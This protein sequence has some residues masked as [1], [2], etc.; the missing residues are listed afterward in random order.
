EI[1]PDFSASSH[2]SSSP[3]TSDSQLNTQLSLVSSD[4][5]RS[6]HACARRKS[7]NDAQ[8][9]ACEASQLACVLTSAPGSS[10][11]TSQL[12]RSSNNFH[13]RRRSPHVKYRTRAFD[14]SRANARSEE[15]TSE[16]QS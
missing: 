14:G 2:R 1:S 15:H 4:L 10:G 3:N 7:R 12:R 9:T 6:M 16:L 13:P 11:C 8:V 5:A